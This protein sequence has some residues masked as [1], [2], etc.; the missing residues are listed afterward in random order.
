MLTPEDFNELVASGLSCDDIIKLGHFSATAEWA[1]ENMGTSHKG[2]VFRYLD[3]ATGEPYMVNGKPFYRIK[4]RDWDKTW[5]DPVDEPPKYLSPK[6]SGNRPYFSPLIQ[7]FEKLSKRPVPI[8]I[9]EGEKK[10]DCLAANDIFSLGLPGVYGWLDST[11]RDEEFDLPPAQLIEDDEEATDSL[12]K[13]DKSRMLPELRRS[14]NWYLR[15][16]H[17]VFDSDII[18]KFQVKQACLGLALALKDLGAY[19]VIVR[20]PNEIDG[21]KNGVDDFI[22]RHGKEAYLVLRENAKIAVIKDKLYFPTDPEPMLKILMSWSVLKDTWRYRPGFGWYRWEETHWV[23]KKPD[24]F[25]IDLIRFQDAQGWRFTGGLDGIIRQLKSRLSVPEIKWNPSWA[26]TFSNGTLDCESNKFSGG[27]K[28]EN[29]CTTTTGY[30]CNLAMNCPTWLSFLQDSLN[31]DEKTIALLQAFIKWILTPKPINKKNKIEKCLDL[32]GPKGSGKGTFLEVLTALVGE[33]NYTAIGG[34][35]FK[36]FNNISSLLGKKLAIDY[37]AFGSLVDVGLFNKIISNEPIQVKL[38]YN[39]PIE[40]RLG[41]VVIVRAY[42]QTLEVPDGSQGLDRRIIAVSFKNRPKT[43]DV[44]LSEKLEAELPGIFQWA[45][46]VPLADA[47]NC[48]LRAGECNA[49]AEA[50]S[51]RFETNN[52]EFRFLTS[53][54]PTGGNVKAGDAYSAYHS[55][56]KEA[57]EKV[58]GSR[59]FFE[60]LQALGCTKSSKSNGCFYYEIPKMRDFDI[61]SHLGLSTP[62]G[63]VDSDFRESFREDSNPDGERDRE[64]RE[65][66]GSKSILSDESENAIA[67]VAPPPT[68]ALEESAIAKDG[69][70]VKRSNGLHGTLLKDSGRLG[71]TIQWDGEDNPRRHGLSELTMI[72]VEV[73]GNKVHPPIHYELAVG[74]HVQYC[75]SE[76]QLRI[77]YTNSFLIIKKISRTKDGIKTATC[78]SIGGTRNGL[79]FPLT[80]LRLRQ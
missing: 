2:L 16:V 62:S 36:N 75:G 73:I 8:D 74:D 6:D 25:E 3:P 60:S 57:G 65:G 70:R 68:P 79:V 71:M 32:V 10:A 17:I 18:A 4:P 42:N 34:E 47:K 29:F 46:R 50:S 58:K 21:S 64:S 77:K 51:S 12:S 35:T 59:K 76:P 43:I 78:S 20:L 61:L 48:L 13:L 56:A 38:L 53:V 67:Q 9:T 52:P 15:Q 37:D 28:R 19:P 41:P 66:F 30:A 49:V 80:D 5:T 26:M 7:H 44:E 1:K 31:G 14:I 24:E 23:L 39:N 11:V 69:L 45:W 72:E 55:W 40:T 27:H 22:C 63:R 54:F 33:G